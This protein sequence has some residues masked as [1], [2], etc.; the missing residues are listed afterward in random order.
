MTLPFV[1]LACM[2]N[3]CRGK[4]I[5][6]L[7]CSIVI[8]Q[9]WLKHDLRLDDHPG[10]IQAADSASLVVPFFCLVPTLYVHLLRTPNG[11][12]GRECS[13]RHQ[14]GNHTLSNPFYCHKVGLMDPMHGSS[15]RTVC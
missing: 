11:I 9:V 2:A 4:N 1:G 14:G 7:I 12:D 6:K 10:F 5:H 15:S 8:T 13:E 3:D